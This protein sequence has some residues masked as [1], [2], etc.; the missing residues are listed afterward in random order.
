[1]KRKGVLAVIG[2][3]GAI[4]WP[5]AF[6]FGFPGVMAPYWQQIFNVGKG[7]IGN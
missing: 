4:F 5:G 1:M 7:A 6:I 2:S 3:A